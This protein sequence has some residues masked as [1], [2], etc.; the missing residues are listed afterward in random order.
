VLLFGA[1]EL[2]VV[3]HFDEQHFRVIPA[4][5]ESRVA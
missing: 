5:S 2:G 3:N 4:D 1:R